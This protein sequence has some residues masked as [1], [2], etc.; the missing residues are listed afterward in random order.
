MSLLFLPS[1]VDACIK[2]TRHDL[3][4][5]LKLCDKQ[6]EEKLA[7]L[8]V[9]LSEAKA[10]KKV[11]QDEADLCALKIGRA[12]E[13]MSGLGGEKSRWTQA[14]EGFGH[15]YIKLTGDILL[16]AGMIAYLGIF[17]PTFRDK[18]IQV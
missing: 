18:I 12:M 9:Q 14:A 8:D 6:V 3:D 10:K 5:L 17:T 7:A 13:L 16:S 2:S 15:T 4:L 1:E 11:V